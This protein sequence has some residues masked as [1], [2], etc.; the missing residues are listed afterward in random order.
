MNLLREI[1]AAKFDLHDA[2]KNEPESTYIDEAHL[3][4]RHALGVLLPKHLGVIDVPHV[5][6]VF[7]LNEVLDC[8]FRH[9]R[10]QF[11]DFG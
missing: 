9:A 5:V 2:V 3:V 8:D 6:R 1:V 7:S 11:S 4:G 10:A